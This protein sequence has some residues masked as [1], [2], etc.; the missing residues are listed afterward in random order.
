MYV[1]IDKFLVKKIL[2]S[3]ISKES[4]REGWIDMEGE[5]N[6]V[7]AHLVVQFVVNNSSLNFQ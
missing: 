5:W 4:E 3:N 7:S 6:K 2:N 1:K